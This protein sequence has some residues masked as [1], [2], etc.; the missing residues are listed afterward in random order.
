MAKTPASILIVDDDPGILAASQM[1]LK[2]LFTLV[3]V[4]NDPQQ[5]PLLIKEQKYNVILLDMNFTLGK[6]DG[7]EG[8]YWLNR[9]LEQDPSSVVVFITAFAGV[10]LAVEAMRSGAFDFIVKPW[11]NERLLRVI[12]TALKLS[13]TKQEA[14]K[15]RHRQ[16]QL[17]QDMDRLSGMII[18]N[19]LPM[20]KVFSLVDKVADTDADILLLGENG[21]G[22]ELVARE[23][24]RK[25]SRRNEVFINVD[26]GAIHEN[27]FESELFGHV[28]G[29]FTDA[30]RDK[31]GRFEVASGGTLFLDEIGNLSLPLQAK[32]L[33]VL[34]NRKVTRLGSN[35][36]IPVDVRLIC[37]T[38]MPLYEMTQRKE[39]REDL[40]YRINMVEVRIPPLRERTG[41]LQ[42][43]SEYFLN[44]YSQ[45]HKKQGLRIPQRTLDRLEKY[46]WPG[47]V[48]ELQHA[49]ERAV[50]L[51]EDNVLNFSDLITDFS[52]QA[53]KQEAENLN[54]RLMEKKLILKAISTNRGNMTRAA[55]DLG[56]ARPALYRRLKKHGL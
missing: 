16:E 17:L 44:R 33:S 29:A 30:S 7:S 9:I 49:I 6:N 23:I 50:I 11:K 25:S 39:F 35:K 56:I 15:Y 52:V 4:E 19:S 26:L 36:E 12:R 37:A 38:N 43:L 40:L 55:A 21:T 46:S 47:N 13:E 34:Q 22:K 31:P 2:Q 32:L 24:H 27:L 51:A 41:D 45:K 8:I 14:E 42:L 54:L 53:Q 3:Q 28:K 10:D 20:Q 5:I 1:F 48:R 18:G